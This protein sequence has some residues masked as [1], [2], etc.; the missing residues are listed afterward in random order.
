LGG[1]GG[2]GGGGGELQYSLALS[3]S[4]NVTDRELAPRFH[5]INVLHISFSFLF[6]WYPIFHSKTLC[7]W[8]TLIA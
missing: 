8:G 1:G 7:N 3:D 2:G 5:S 4:G 6:F